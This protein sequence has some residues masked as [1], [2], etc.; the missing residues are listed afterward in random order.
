[1]AKGDARTYQSA[2]VDTEQ[3]DRAMLSVKDWAEKT[4]LFRPGE[5]KLP[6]GYFAN[7]VDIGNGD[8]IAVS[9]DGVGTKII[10]AQM[11][12]KYD[13][14]GIDCVAMNVND[15]ICVGAEPIALLDYIAVEGARPAFLSD[16]MKGIHDGA[17]MANVTVPGGEIAQVKEMI[18]GPRPGCAFDLVGTAIGRVR[19]DAILDGRTIL[20]GDAIVGLRSSG[21]HSNGFS[22]V[23]R[24]IFEQLGWTV[25]HQVP[26]LGRSIGEALLEPTRIYVREAVAM[27][28]RKLDIKA[29]AH[30]TSSGFLNLSRAAADVA[31]V[32]DKLP[33]PAPIFKVIQ[34]GGDIGIEEMYFTYNMGIGFVIVVNPRDVDAVCS[35]A[36][37][38]GSDPI[39][40]GHTEA[41]PRR[42]VRIPA[43][44]LIGVDGKFSKG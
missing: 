17:K 23:R 8:G 38:N 26:E 40:I 22:L 15:V 21:V 19:N 41:D 43:H 44:R 1:M 27:L 39:I 3:Q 7:V 16:L 14:V 25:D 31:Y 11:L 42:E 36:R 35:I 34:Q 29:F 30:I 18:R 28:R 5:V 9:T 37:E 13:T 6:I 4:F 32:L 24:V 2:G 20:P 33:E 12:D 10:I